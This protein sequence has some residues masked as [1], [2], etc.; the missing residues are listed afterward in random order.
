MI[1]ARRANSGVPVFPARQCFSKEALVSQK[2]LASILFACAL[3]LS[4]T[5]AQN[6]PQ[7]AASPPQNSSA[8]TPD[9]AKRAL[10]TL[11]DDGKRAQMIDT[12][13][14]IANASPRLRPM[15]R[16]P[17]QRPHRLR[18]RNPRSR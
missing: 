7:A 5:L 16:K 11:Q 8:L 3:S 4:P 13:R 15:R 10:D 1:Q 18:L 14:A 17:G 2:L 9:Q 12:L 6:A